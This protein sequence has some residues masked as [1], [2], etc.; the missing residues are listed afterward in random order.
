MSF[1]NTSK[2]IT[3]EDSYPFDLTKYHQTRLLELEDLDTIL[4]QE[5]IAI[6]TDKFIS[7]HQRYS[8]IFNTLYKSSYNTGT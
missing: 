1:Q 4:K 6:G 5:S 8:I 3:F 7:S 2:L